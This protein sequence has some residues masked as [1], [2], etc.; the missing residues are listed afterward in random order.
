MR[1]YKFIFWAMALILSPVLCYAQ[2]PFGYRDFTN[3]EY[4]VTHSGQS[5]GTWSG[6]DI[7]DSGSGEIDV[8]AGTGVIKKTNSATARNYYF[9]YAGETDIS[10]NDNSTNWIY[11]DYNSGNPIAAANIDITAI[12]KR[13]QIIIGRV[14]RSG[15]DLN[16]IEAGQHFQDYQMINCLHD[17]EVHDFERASGEI[18]GETGT[19]NIT[20]SAGVD[21]CAHNRFT[22]AAFDSSGT[23]RFEYWYYNGSAWV[24]VLSQS[25]IDNANYNN[26]AS[27]LAALTSNRY[28]VFWVFRGYDGTVDIIYG[29]G[30]YT[31]SEAE[32]AIVPATLPDLIQNFHFLIGK[33]II[34]EDASSFTEIASAFDT[35]FNFTPVT[36]HTDLSTLVWGSS[37][38]T[39]TASNFAGFDGAGAATY[40][41]EANYL[42]AAG[43]RA[44]T[45]DWDAGAY[46]IRAETLESDVATGTAPLT[47]ASTTEVANLHA[48][49]ATSLH[50]NGSNCSSGSAPLGVDASGNAESCFDVWT[51]AE[52]T[53]AGY[54]KADGT[55]P[56]TAD[57]DAGAFEIRAETFESDVTT[58]T[59]PLTVASTTLNT[60]LNADLLDGQT[61]SYYLDLG[62]STG[63]AWSVIYTDGSGNSTEVPLGTSGTALQSNGPAAAPSFSSYGIYSP[64]NDGDFL[65]WDDVRNTY[66]PTGAISLRSDTGIDFAKYIGSNDATPT[67]TSNTTPSGTIE[68]AY[69]NADAYEAFDDINGSY[70]W[71]YTLSTEPLPVWITY[72]F[73]SST[74]ITGYTLT[75][76]S[77][78]NNRMPS[79]WYFQGWN[80]SDWD[81]L[82][83]QTGV[84]FDADEK[85]TYNLSVLVS[86]SK[87]RLYVT[88]T[89]NAAYFSCSEIE[90]L[91]DGAAFLAHSI[92]TAD[93]DWGFGTLGPDRQVDILDDTDPQLR[94]S[95]TDG[96]I[97]T[98]LQTDSNGDLTITTTGNKV[99]ITGLSAHTADADTIADSGDGNPATATLTPTSSYIELTC[100][101]A[102]TCDIT[103][104]ETGMEE[105]M[106][107]N[108][109]NVS[110]NACDFSDSAGVSELAGSFAMGQYDVLSLLYSGD[111]WIEISRS[112]N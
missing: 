34:Q 90:L 41:P 75:A 42:L 1:Q 47:I 71:T 26:I 58:G 11:I 7:T 108:I 14:Y 74:D 83:Y 46:E 15:N 110:T 106:T 43:T 28:G 65:A 66:Y 37:A 52:N 73:A 8:A 89:P 30:N 68:A 104:G 54:L 19:R 99:E 80:G 96:S 62:N 49:T 78:F 85:K 92:M 22:T 51:E 88:D 103:M 97:Y 59:A 4:S 109:V 17:F 12:N 81:D 23:D 35:Q 70:D 13:T 18:L 32:A 95:H 20:V 107:V 94:L 36:D 98:D 27:G 39:G 53:A 21:Y 84:S 87:Y 76:G 57:W 45:G 16:I 101:D 10:L 38:H 48:D 100:S 61:G 72:D 5:A 50:A 102:D 112:N 60:N 55:I 9:E 2:F 3:T 64:G 29:Q 82:D 56:L 86:Y 24:E 67:M 25:Q 40:Y 31:L 44:L 79:T 6:F 69:S 93:D 111:T 91:D 33:I 105:G 63:T 77:S